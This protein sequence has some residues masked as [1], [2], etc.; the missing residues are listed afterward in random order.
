MKSADWIK[1][2]DVII[3]AMHK[4]LM[5][6]PDFKDQYLASLNQ[7]VDLSLSTD[8][9]FF[10]HAFQPLYVAQLAQD[11]KQKDNSESPHE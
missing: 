1:Q 4:F 10:L 8:G 7:L 2:R 6:H 3:L 9:D 5:N 11:S